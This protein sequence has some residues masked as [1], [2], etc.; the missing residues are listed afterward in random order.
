MSRSR[1]DPKRELCS[2]RSAMNRL[3]E[4][5]CVLPDMSKVATKHKRYGSRG[6]PFA[7]GNAK[8]GSSLPHLWASRSNLQKEGEQ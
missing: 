8:G 3:M 7:D 5:S 4:E 2:L 1:F 6:P